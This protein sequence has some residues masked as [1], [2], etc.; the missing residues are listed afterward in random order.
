MDGP[1]TSSTRR[2]LLTS[3]DNNAWIGLLLVVLGG[4]YSLQWIVL[5]GVYSLQ[6]IIMHG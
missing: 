4:V 2:S 6:W 1:T 5:G 3:M